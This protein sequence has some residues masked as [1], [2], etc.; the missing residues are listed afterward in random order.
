MED[1]LIGRAS[2]ISAKNRLLG[3]HRVKFILHWV[4]AMVR[5][6]HLRILQLVI[7]VEHHGVVHFWHYASLELTA[8]AA[9]RVTTVIASTLPWP[10]LGLKVVVAI[11][12]TLV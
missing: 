5:Q 10:I 9:V 8:L 3:S 12:T 1:S 7:R 6:S 11:G 4:I 2:R